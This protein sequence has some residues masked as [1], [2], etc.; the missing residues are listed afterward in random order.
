[1]V[2]RISFKTEP[3]LSIHTSRGD[4]DSV[5]HLEFENRLPIGVHLP[6][7]S[8]ALLTGDCTIASF[9]FL[10]ASISHLLAL[11][12][13]R[14]SLGPALHARMIHLP[15]TLTLASSPAGSHQI[16][17]SSPDLEVHATSSP[18][19]LRRTCRR[20]NKAWGNAPTV[21]VKSQ[22]SIYRYDF[23]T[24][25][26]ISIPSINCLD[27]FPHSHFPSRIFSSLIHS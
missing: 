24:I 2:L 6:F 21:I 11:R 10:E 19:S 26:P 1:M 9:V 14:Q 25:S 8:L 17:F 23:I 15:P 3:K 16:K 22:S 12:R 20:I 18:E 4:V 27:S 5:V 7:L 13:S